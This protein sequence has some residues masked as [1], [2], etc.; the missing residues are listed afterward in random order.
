MKNFIKLTSVFFL[1]SFVETISGQ[2]LLLDQGKSDYQIVISSVATSEEIKAASVF[3]EYFNKISGVRLNIVKDDSAPSSHEI[4]IGKSKRFGPDHIKARF[5]DSEEDGFLILTKNNKLIIIGAS[6]KGTLNGVYTFLEDYLGCRLYSTDLMIVPE[7]K[8]IELP[9]IKDRQIPVFTFREMLFPGRY[10]TNYLAWHKLHSHHDGSWGMWVHTFDDLVPPEIYFKD[11]P[12]YFSEINGKRT[13]KGQLCLSNPDVF[14]VL[15]ANLQKKMKA[16]PEADYWSVSQN[17]NFLSCQCGECKKIAEQYGGESG[18]MIWFVNRVAALFPEKTISTLAYQ[19]TRPAPKHIKPLPNVNIMLCTIE[20]NRSKPIAEDPSSASFVRDNRDWTRLTDNILIWDYVVQFRNYI[21]PFPNLDVLQPN[22]EFFA[23]QGCRLM[24]Q[25]GSNTSLSE[26]IDLRSYIIAK[27]LWNPELDPEE[28]RSEFIYNYY[29]QAAPF[30]SEYINM[31]H[32]ELESTGGDLWIY[33]YPYTGIESF[34]RPALIPVYKGLMDKAQEAV[35]DQP[36]Y[37]DRVLFARLPLDYA[38]LDISLH[39]VDDDLCWFSEKEGR[40]EIN[41]EMVNLL[42]TFVNR[43]KRLNVNTLNEQNFP[44]EEYRNMVKKYLLKSS[45]RHIAL[46][47]PVELMTTFSPKYEAGG[48][49][50]LT[51]GLRGI[52]DYHFNWLGFEG[53]DLEAV[54]DLGEAMPVSEISVDFL[55]DIQSWVFLPESLTVFG[56]TNEEDLVKLGTV[57]NITP[58][59]KPGAFIQTFTVKGSQIMARYIRVR[60]KSL[61]TC[62]DWHIGAGEK[63]WIFTDEIVVK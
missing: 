42:D 44:P 6:P 3:Q 5:K 60:A 33:G 10:D 20:C 50:A 37:Y 51:D 45:D 59:D 21:S 61:K 56:S 46:N 39:K 36:V 54:I 32:E 35:Q 15:T 63:S 27:L 9:A 11:H 40:F 24:F 25:Q 16:Q 17:D 34:L 41:E 43:C 30:I 19:Y 52:N 12:E 55:Q 47:K 2:T 38:I 53:E 28:I 22:L 4:L 23:N 8:T 7:K 62:P 14:N 29:G 48:A 58:D 31:L 18:L 57:E 13:D 26:F 1:F 49:A